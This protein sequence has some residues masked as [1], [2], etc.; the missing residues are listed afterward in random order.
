MPLQPVFPAILIGTLLSALPA[1]AAETPPYNRQVD[2]R[3][4]TSAEQ[5]A[6]RREAQRHHF[7]RLQFCADP[8]N[9]PLS[10]NRGEGLENR[11]A[12]V[13][14]RRMGAQLSYFWRPSYERGL[15]REPFDNNQCQILIEI[16]ADYPRVLTT[17]PI[18][19]STYVFATR[20]DAG[21]TID[22]LDDPDLRTKRI[23]VFQMS[24]LREALARRGIRSGLDE[25]V[26]S[27]DA[28]LEPENQPWTQVQKVVD[29]RLDIA[30]VWG[31]FAG[32]VKARGEKIVLTPANRMEDRIP[33]EFSMAFG[34]PTN[35]AVLKYALDFALLASRD[36]IAAILRAFG[37]PLVQCGDCVVSGDIPSHGSYFDAII[38]RSSQRF[39]APVPEEHRR[40]DRS[41]ASPDQVMTVDRVDRALADG[42]DL[43][44]EFANAVLGSD[45]A[46]A[47]HLLA[48]GADVN[49]PDR[50]GTTPLVTAA[51][52][53]DE[54]M[55]T[56]LLDAGAAI[57]ARDRAGMTALHQAVLRN[58]VPTIRLLVSRGADL[59]APG[60]G[61][62]TPLALA[63]SEG[64]RWAAMAL[65]EAGAPVN[66]ASGGEGLTPLM[67]LAT[68]DEAH[69]RDDRAIFGPSVVA[70]AEALIA[71]GAE[72]NAA[73]R[74]GVTALMIAAGGDHVDMLAYLLK[75]GADPARSN[76]AGHT[77]LQIAELS[78]SGRAA[79]ALRNLV[80]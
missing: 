30:A 52:D 67:L 6:A 77:A 35:D 1:A 3:T 74:D 57:N 50:Q 16:P 39:T 61:G 79:L 10:D 41:R 26:L 45:Q 48:K 19:R 62:L 70:I 51:R 44:E 64:L 20:A 24:G 21:F 40:L 71:R 60:P 56:L 53:R 72:V 47:R 29:G 76:A 4:M 7:E 5:T 73:T 17:V 37:V 15:T 28:D 49:A 75:A 63:A 42:A 69:Q 11:I 27:Y 2:F 31:P 13:I 36:E 23:G 66:Q 80:R 55:I 32:W 58:H 54:G 78:R 68:R 59:S 25:H 14:A 46:R 8:G 9:M 65:I 34:V 22:G 18:Y 33:L 12:A 38:E 43:Q